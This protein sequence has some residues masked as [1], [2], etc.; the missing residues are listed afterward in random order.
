MKQKYIV[1]DIV[2]YKN[3]I[4]KIINTLGFNNYVLS[5][6]RHPVNQSELSGFPLTHE[7]L[8]KNGWYGETHSK[9]SDGNTKILYKT[10]KRKGYPTIKVSQD[11]KNT[12][13]MSTF[14]VK[15]ESVSDLQHLLFCL[16]LNSEMKV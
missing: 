14:I 2:M 4:R 5:Y 12:C 3:R 6:V 9:Q 11:L 15:L 1:G 10:F 16:G 8:E 13:E 7:I